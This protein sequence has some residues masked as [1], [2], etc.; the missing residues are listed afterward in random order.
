M[1]RNMKEDEIVYMIKPEWITWDEVQECQAQS[2]RRNIKK[3]L[4]MHCTELTGAEL[5]K[6][7]EGGICFVAL[8][9]KKVVGTASLI[10]QESRKFILKKRL[11]YL[12]MEGVLPEYQGSD[13]Y[14]GLQDIR[15]K[16]I[17]DNDIDILYSDTAENNKLVRKLQALQGYKNIYYISFR[18]TDYYS[19][20]MAKWIK[21]KPIPDFFL[22]PFFFLSE[23][24][25]KLRFKPHRI[26]RFGI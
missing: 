5:E 1:T 20:T 13:V 8:E 6:K 26:K 11:G 19:V 21:G 14:F 4:K 25:V 16:Y 12:C 17:M 9:G 22:K 10:I 2:H 24:Y 3:G 7:L 15:M 18:S 23:K